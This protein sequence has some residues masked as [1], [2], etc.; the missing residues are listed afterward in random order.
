MTWIAE[1]KRS[2][3]EWATIKLLKVGPIPHHIAFIMDGNRRFAKQQEKQTIEG[4]SEGFRKLTEVL[5][6]C[7][8][9]GITEVTVYAF[10]IENFKR[11]KAEVDGLMRLCEEKFTD[12]LGET[13]KLKEFGVCI[14]VIGNISLLT[15]KLRNLVA[16]AVL[17]T[18]DNS[19]YFLNIALAYTSRDEIV[20]AMNEMNLAAR[21]EMLKVSDF[22]EELLENSLYTAGINDPDLLI[23]TSGETR[24]SDFLLWQSAFTHLFFTKV[25][26]PQISFWHLAVAVFQYQRHHHTL[27]HLKMKDRRRRKEEEEQSDS[28]TWIENGREGT[29]CDHV[30]EKR[31]RISNYLNQLHSKRLDYLIEVA[32]KEF[33]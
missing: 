9:F 31:E 8:D 22:S 27:A 28:E 15:P 26:W 1:P 11:S 30:S 13:D 7:R 25:L 10:S 32:S 3:A 6:W 17:A 12:L 18:K 21:N 23:R 19:K 33:S 29:F 14:R 2:W 5:S 20:T 16:K 24:L 4:H